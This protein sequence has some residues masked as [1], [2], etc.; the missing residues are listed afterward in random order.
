MI[1]RSQSPSETSGMPAGLVPL[2][3]EPDLGGLRKLTKLAGVGRGT[4]RRIPS[5]AREGFRSA[6]C[7]DTRYAAGSC[8]TQEGRT[9]S[10]V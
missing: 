1:L 3:P 6:E 7:L 5:V 9:S 8:G 2:N 4:L 10:L